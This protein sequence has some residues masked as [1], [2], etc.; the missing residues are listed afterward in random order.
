[1]F[2]NFQRSSTPKI[3]G[4]TLSGYFWDFKLREGRVDCRSVRTNLWGNIGSINSQSAP[5]HFCIIIS[6]DRPESYYGLLP[7]WSKSAFGAIINVCMRDI[8]KKMELLKV[9]FFKETKET[10]ISSLDCNGDLLDHWSRQWDCSY[11]LFTWQLQGTHKETRVRR[12][13]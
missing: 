3:R 4:S 2:H 11:D 6:E 12:A 13:P 8:T 7:D 5:C 1:M 9:L 10:K